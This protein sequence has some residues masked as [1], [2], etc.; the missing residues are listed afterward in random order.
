VQEPPDR[1]DRRISSPDGTPIAVFRS[2][3]GPPLVLVHGAA[4]DHTTWR[5]ILPLLARHFTIH[6][7]D[8]RGRGASGDTSPYAVEREFEDLA[9]VVDALVAETRAPVALVGHSF[10]GRVALGAA[11]RTSNVAGVVCYEGAPAPAGAPYQRPG[12]VAELERLA[13]GGERAALLETFLRSVVGMS[14]LDL[15]AY[16][17]T[18]VWP[19]R[20]DA[21]PTILRELRAEAS[22]AAGLEELGG[23]AAPVLLLLGGASLPAFHAATA[24][25]A[26]RLSRVRVS[27]IED[28]RH[29][30]H[31]THPD[32]FVAE[33]LAFFGSPAGRSGPPR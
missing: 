18:T 9:A 7:V 33:V 14:E 20:V 11:L 24:A 1:P 5:V 10:G 29:A 28:A 2:G 3:D 17:A 4:A 6:A 23:V 22:A 25:L 13:V 31:H 8:R 19:R 21:A 27:I 26:A 32:R 15:A 12:L 30:A 16:R